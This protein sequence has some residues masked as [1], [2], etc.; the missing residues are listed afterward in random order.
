M[1]FPLFWDATYIF[2]IIGA[3]LSLLAQA[4]VTSTF[5]KYSRIGTKSGMTG[6]DAARLILNRNRIHSVRIEPVRGQLTDHYNPQKMSLALSEPVYGSNSIAAVGVA[7]HEC[8]HA[9]Q[10]DQQYGPLML[11]SALVPITNIGSTLSIPILLVGML[12]NSSTG[13]LLVQIGI[14]AFSL[15]TLFT[16]ITLPVEFNASRRAL[17]ILNENH[18]LT[19]EEL[20]GTREVLNAAAMTYVAAAA[21]S[22]LQLLRLLLISGNRRRD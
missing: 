15:T 17:A 21:T 3:A 10:H 1:F 16:L 9:V 4:R 5:N 6:A 2:V 22:I 13:D 11:R 20:K 18:V 14:I 19:E 12:L 7:A 8:G